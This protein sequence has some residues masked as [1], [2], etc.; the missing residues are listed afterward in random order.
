ME[1]ELRFGKT[2]GERPKVYKHRMNCA[3]RQNIADVLTKKVGFE[4]HK[5]ADDHD[6]AYAPKKGRKVRMSVGGAKP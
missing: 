3:D 4:V 6:W 2:N 5:L 1:H